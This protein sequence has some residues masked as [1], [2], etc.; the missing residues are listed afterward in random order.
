MRDLD[1]QFLFM[2]L[3]CL[4][5]LTAYDSYGSEDAISIPVELEIE[6]KTRPCAW[7]LYQDIGKRSRSVLGLEILLQK[8]CHILFP[9]GPP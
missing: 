3:L 9:P 2:F 7:H 6:A 4:A 5:A 1:A 8:N